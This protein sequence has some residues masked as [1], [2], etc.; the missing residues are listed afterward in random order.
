MPTKEQLEQQKSALE[1]QIK[2]FVEQL[3][4]LSDETKEQTKQKIIELEN[5]REK[6]LEQLITTIKKEL[7]NISGDVESKQLQD[8]IETYEREE[9]ENQSYYADVIA[10]IEQ[11]N[12][13][14][15]QELLSAIKIKVAS[16]ER[17]QE[18][19][20]INDERTV[21]STSELLKGTETEKR[22]L[23]ILKASEFATYGETPEKRLETI[24][25]K[26]HT[27][28]ESFL[29]SKFALDKTK[30]TV[31]PM[32]TDVLTP[33]IEWYLMDFLKQNQHENNVADLSL[34]D[35]ISFDTF[36][37]L[38]NSVSNFAGKATATYG[39]GKSLLRAI[40]FLSVHK[41]ALL[42]ANQSDILRNPLKCKEFLEH[43]LWATEQDIYSISL[44][45]VGIT[46]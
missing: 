23:N 29:V 28:I 2:E 33:A 10:L 8:L 13:T 3:A 45:D 36:K 26:I 39:K 46:F 19:L 38:F 21:I 6:V 18:H 43:P 4:T 15:G 31:P 41:E 1:Q 12:S 24:L 14:S 27:T 16:S 25:G 44:A 22:L 5:Q 35:G 11:D 30:E 34:A 32:L 42:K 7:E 20:E 9:W 37:D 40:D 17:E